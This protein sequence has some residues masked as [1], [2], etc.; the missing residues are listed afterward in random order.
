MYYINSV[1][2]LEIKNLGF[3]YRKSNLEA[4]SEINLEISGGEFVAIMGM[5]GAGKSTLLMTFNGIIPH[6]IKGDFRGEVVSFGKN[7]LTHKSRDYFKEIGLVFQD[8]ESQIFS[9]AVE[10]EVAFGLENI[11]LEKLE[12]VRRVDETL[13]F[14]GLTHLK[15]RNPF[16][17]SGGEKQRLAIAAVLA[18]KPKL[19]AFDEPTTDLDPEARGRIYS[20][21]KELKS[22][23]RS[24]ITVEHDADKVKNADRL[25]VLK[26]GR[27]LK[28]GPPESILKEIK[29]LKENGIQPLEITELFSE[30][31][32]KELP[33]NL[34][35]AVSIVKRD[36]WKFDQESIRE[37][38]SKG[39]KSGGKTIF[40]LDGVNFSYGE[41]KVL[42]NINLEVKEGE[43][44]SIVGPNGSGKTTLAK[45]LAGIFKPQKG[46][47]YIN[48]IDV[49]KMEPV[50]M[51]RL[52][53]FGFQNPDHQIFKEKVEDEIDFTLSL[54]RK[55][56]LNKSEMIDEALNAVNLLEKR[57]EDPFS[58]TKGERQRLAVASIL[59]AKK[60][61]IILD[62]PITGLDWNETRE[63][64]K[65]IKKL[66]E[67]GKTILIITH[68]VDIAIR[69]SSRILILK[70]GKIIADGIPR[71]LIK[72]KN[73]WED[74]HIPLSDFFHLNEYLGFNFLDVEE[75]KHSLIQ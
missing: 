59:A 3:R 10:L 73:L 23:K 41:K 66:N 33:L 54:L 24:F 68:S 28:D 29:F 35:D 60:E 47:L 15:N 45:I 40:K 58:L 13:D 22:L 4:L 25:V 56:I 71:E 62:E 31:G 67:E 42:E 43:F 20:L 70:D 55:D 36:R 51:S 38:V 11:N 50:S 74:S 14:I 26:G 52:I 64:M 34:S 53:G 6:F 16:F 37:I 48:G 1:K 32:Y 63:M 30:L 19:L 39:R 72:D 21:Y 7:T 9:S 44:L 27:I 17:L 61:I 8:F 57:K 69:Y 2:I 75:I 49:K 46:N 12:M 65:L 5:S 18:M